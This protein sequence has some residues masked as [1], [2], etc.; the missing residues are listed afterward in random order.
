MPDEHKHLGV[1][2]A[3]GV[4]AEVAALRRNVEPKNPVSYFPYYT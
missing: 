3:L 4:P 1:V 2:V